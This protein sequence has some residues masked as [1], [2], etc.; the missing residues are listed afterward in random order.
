MRDINNPFK[1]EMV[2]DRN[3]TLDMDKFNL[4]EYLAEQTKPFVEG[5]IEDLGD[6]GICDHV[7]GGG[8]Q[9]KWK[10]C[11]PPMPVG[12]RH[13]CKKAP[14]KLSRACNTKPCQ[15]GQSESKI[16]VMDES[17]R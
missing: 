1:S 4:K 10:G 6:W 16:P 14:V 15:K 9:V 7:C 17:W 13:A 11:K 2:S 5:E 12:P 3:F 8:N